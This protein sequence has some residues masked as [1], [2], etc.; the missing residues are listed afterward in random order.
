[1]ASAGPSRGAAIG[2]PIQASRPTYSR[3][4]WAARLGEAWARA[5]RG[6]RNRRF[7]MDAVMTAATIIKRYAVAYWPTAFVAIGESQDDR[8]AC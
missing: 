4:S 1:M 3:D 5:Q 6:G 7:H 8:A 2:S